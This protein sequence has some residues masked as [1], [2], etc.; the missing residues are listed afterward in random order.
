MLSFAMSSLIS[1]RQGITT[2]ALVVKFDE[3]WR[4]VGVPWIP[5]STLRQDVET[6]YAPFEGTN[7]RQ[8]FPRN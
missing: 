1:N 3:N 2:K 7:K 8:V 4:N 5:G 6:E